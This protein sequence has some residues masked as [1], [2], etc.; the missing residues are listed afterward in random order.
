MKAR[1]E[2][3]KVLTGSID[4]AEYGG[5]ENT[6]KRVYDTFKTEFFHENELKRQGGSMPRV[7]AEWL[8]GLPSVID[9][10]FYTE[11]IINLMYA[12]GY[13]TKEMEDIDIDSLY[14]MELGYIIDLHKKYVAP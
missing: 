3:A 14:W 9:M 2:L 11:N 5:G 4:F 7:I 12:V 8:R 1:K 13:D 6:L 10:P